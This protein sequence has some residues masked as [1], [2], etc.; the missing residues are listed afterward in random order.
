MKRS[1][2]LIHTFSGFCVSLKKSLKF[3]E[4]GEGVGENWGVAA[5]GYRAF[6]LL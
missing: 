2:K 1:P 3:I 6:F 4:A 5:N